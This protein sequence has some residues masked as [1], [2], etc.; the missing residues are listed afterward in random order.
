MLR[1]I[2]TCAGESWKFLLGDAVLGWL[3]V[4]ILSSW[5]L[6]IIN[7]RRMSPLSQNLSNKQRRKRLPLHFSIFKGLLYLVS[8]VGVK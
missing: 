2:N 7:T 4:F 1:T 6:I 8:F 5:F 3:V